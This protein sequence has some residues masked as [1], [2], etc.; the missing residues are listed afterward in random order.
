MNNIKTANILIIVVLVL[1]IGSGIYNLM[2]INKMADEAS[3]ATS[4]DNGVKEFTGSPSTLA[5]KLTGKK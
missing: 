5:K 2:L 3:K 1:L 4:T